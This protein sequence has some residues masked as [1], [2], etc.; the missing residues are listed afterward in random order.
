MTLEVF[1]Y[2]AIASVVCVVFLLGALRI[3]KKLDRNRL[4]KIIIVF[5][6][7]M[8]FLKFAEYYL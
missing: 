5:L 8:A 2:S 7:V 3:F 1:I 4:T 6:I